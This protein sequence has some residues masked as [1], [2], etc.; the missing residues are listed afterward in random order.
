M[1]RN[2][3]VRQ[4]AEAD[5]PAITAIYGEAV[6]AGTGSFELEAPDVAVMTGRWRKRVVRG[7]PHI[8]ATSGDAVI[9][10]AYASRYRTSPAYSFL[11]ED[12][13]YVAS[14]ARG[15]GVGGALLTELVKRP[16]E[17]LTKAALMDVA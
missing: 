3:L 15:A 13:I 4:T 1:P 6:S 7:Y 5:L 14:S 11:V 16:G 2:V 9:G 17:V 10:Y 8:V 12:S